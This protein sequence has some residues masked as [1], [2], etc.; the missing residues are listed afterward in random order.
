MAHSWVMQAPST[1]T[2]PQPHAGEQGRAVHWPPTHLDPLAQPQVPPHPSVAPHEPS[3]GHCALQQAPMYSLVPLPHGQVPPQ[4][5]VLPPRVPSAG[6][7]G[8][9]HWPP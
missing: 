7:S 2:W 9:Q 1:Q 4:P 6:H 5:S 8:E 3:I